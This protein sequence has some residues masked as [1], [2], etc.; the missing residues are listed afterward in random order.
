M[1]NQIRIYEIFDE[2]K[3]S[4]LDRFDRHA[5]RIMESHGFNIVAMWET[6]KDEKPAFAYLLNWRSEEEMKS[7]WEAF[8]ADEEWK[9]IKRQTAP[10]SG[11]IVGEISDYTLKPASFSKA[12]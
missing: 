7:A 6:T 2:T 3:E 5:A 8:M 10:E 9:E 1:I 12:I 11:N 4:F